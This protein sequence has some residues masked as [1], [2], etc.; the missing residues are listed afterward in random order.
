MK[1]LK[2]LLLLSLSH[3]GD[4]ARLTPRNAAVNHR[5][6]AGRGWN[7]VQMFSMIFFGPNTCTRENSD[8]LLASRQQKKGR[9]VTI[10]ANMLEKGGR[11]YVQFLIN[12]KKIFLSWQVAI[13]ESHCTDQRSQYLHWSFSPDAAK[14]KGNAF[15]LVTS[16]ICRKSFQPTSSHRTTRIPP[17]SLCIKSH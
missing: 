9:I 10:M 2:L 13:S 14:H 12:V 8:L 15:P 6:L 1:R 4:K 16:E 5:L 17:Q 7:T 11:C 3:Y